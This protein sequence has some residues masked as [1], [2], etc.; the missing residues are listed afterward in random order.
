ME[1]IAKAYVDQEDQKEKT[2]K[3]AKKKSGDADNSGDEK[4]KGNDDKG[5]ES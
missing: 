2:E 4:S 3:A 5:N 1:T